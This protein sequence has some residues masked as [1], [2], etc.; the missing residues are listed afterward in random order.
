MEEKKRQN[1]N[2]ENDLEWRKKNKVNFTVSLMRSTDKDI[3]DYLDKKVEEGK[4]RLGVVK[5]AI[6][7]KIS[8]E[9]QD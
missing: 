7:E 4:S 3:I 8:R 6:R 5:E 9:K 1:R 2:K